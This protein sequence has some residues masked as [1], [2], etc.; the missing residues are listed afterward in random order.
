M[1]RRNFIE[2]TALGSTAV[3]S[4]IP[5]QSFSQSKN[6]KIGLIGCGWYG[7]VITKAAFS[8][9]GVE[10]IAIC[11]VDTE[12]LKTSADEIEKLQ[13]KR[14]KEIKDYH[15]LLNQK[16][17]EAV[18]IATPPHWHALHFIAACEKGLDIYCEKPL[19]YDIK[20][21]LA[22]IKAAEKSGNIV[23]IGFQRRQSNAFIKVK[24]LISAGKAGKIHQI[25][26]QIHYNPVLEDTTVQAPPASLDWETWCGPAP[27]LDYRPSIG[28]K[29]W[30]LE[31][32]YGNGHLVDWGIHNIDIIRNIMGFGMP[33][34]FNSS[35]GLI[36]LAGKIT[37]P[38]TLNAIMNF[39]QCPV[40]WQ[41]RLWGS[42]DLNTQFNNGVFFYGETA[43]IFAS[44]NR[45]IIM[46]AGRDQGQEVLEIPTEKMQEN[47]LESFLKAV[48]AKDK[49]LLTCSITD[50][51]QST[52][53]VQLAM[54]SYYTG[55]MVSWNSR[56]MEITGN[57]K[58]SDLLAR[59]YRSGYK[60]PS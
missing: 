41:H 48:K 57:P 28:H 60:R 46:P 1:N 15:D 38:D 18:L 9:G 45:V 13:G 19:A 27:K 20:E 53:T 51:F 56:K 4:F 31:K 23:Q 59:A 30:R 42:G 43:T 32:E 29:A 3:F 34:S 54:I 50:G 40:I 55:S 24:E 21:G 35:G 7:M 8:V 11:D 39:E 52:A 16:G 25:G 17:L 12:H 6:L 37:T 14:P 5:G 47:H 26:A 2:K 44:D 22:M 36:T 49:N 33:N 10:V 58:A